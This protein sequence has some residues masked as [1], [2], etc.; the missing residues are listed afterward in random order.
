VRRAVRAA[1]RDQP[2]GGIPADR[3][4][5]APGGRALHCLDVH[6]LSPAVRLT[7]RIGVSGMVGGCVGG[8]EWGGG[9]EGELRDPRGGGEQRRQR[10]GRGLSRGS[11]DLAEFRLSAFFPERSPARALATAVSPP[12]DFWGANTLLAVRV[13]ASLLLRPLPF[14]VSFDRA[15]SAPQPNH[16]P[17]TGAP[18][19]A[20]CECSARRRAR[21]AA[22]QRC[23]G[24]TQEHV[25]GPSAWA[26]GTDYE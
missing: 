9:G 12:R 1:D 14:A 4:L 18:L 19:E 23:T 6:V 21:S 20:G 24:Y 7:P 8:M 22:L 25:P 17:G 11:A 10:V 3:A 13:E 2:G 5:P 16:G 15:S 26:G